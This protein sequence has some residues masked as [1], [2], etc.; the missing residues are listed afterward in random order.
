LWGIPYLLIREAVKEVS[1][2]I[3]VFSRVLI[4]SIAI[5]PLLLN[6]GVYRN[7]LKH[8]RPIGL[9]AIGEMMIPW[10]LIS[11]AERRISSG[12]AGLLVAT[13]PLWQTIIQSFMGD[14]TVWHKVRLFGLIIG[15]VGI[16]LVVGI[17]SFKGNIN[18]FS[19]GEVIIGSMSYSLA[20]SYVNHK[21]PH[22]NVMAINQIALTMTAIFYLPLA[23]ATWP[24]HAIHI[25]TFVMLVVLGLLPTALAFV[26][27]FGLIRSI[28][29]AR[30]SLVTYLNTAFAVILG[31]IILHE[32]LS[33]GIVVGLPLILLGSYLASKKN[34]VE[35][36]N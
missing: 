22:I 26:L 24:A 27:F 36:K 9:Y 3:I 18:L 10:L 28:G 13:V 2:P 6:K 5:A 15:F 29:A 4:G 8:W 35:G 11:D 33:T 23:I 34:S 30:G 32:P 19:V 25:K 17:D 21:V 14:K 12:L 16:F 7:A 20:T 1:P 31:I